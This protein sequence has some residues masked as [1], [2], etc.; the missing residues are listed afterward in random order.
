MRRS[1]PRG[2][3]LLDRLLA[4]LYNAAL[5]ERIH[6]WRMSGRSISLYDQFGSLTAI[7]KQEPEWIGIP[8]L[9]ARSALVRPDRAMQG[10]FSRVKSGKKP[11]VPR[12][13]ARSRYRSFSVDDPKSARRALRIRDEGCRGELRA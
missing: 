6:S 7:R 4:M 1:C 10:F 3:R 2:Q 12:C 9:V 8:V 13:R 11:G 5:E